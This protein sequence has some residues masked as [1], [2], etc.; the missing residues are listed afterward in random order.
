[1]D[2]NCKTEEIPN[3]IDGKEIEVLIITSIET[4]KRQKGKCGKDEVF[5]LVKDTVEENITTEIFD[6]TLDFLIES[7][8][9]KCSFI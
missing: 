9:V 5:K 8:S 4:V 1:M 7:G 6:K 2:I 3:I